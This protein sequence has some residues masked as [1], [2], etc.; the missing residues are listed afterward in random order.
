MILIGGE[1]LI[2]FIEAADG[3]FTATPGGGP[4]NVA[5]TLAR[6][7][8]SVGYLTPVSTDAMGAR[9]AADLQADGV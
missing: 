9:L 4:Y 2:D 7:G 6:L 1:N 3:R 8:Q 5:K